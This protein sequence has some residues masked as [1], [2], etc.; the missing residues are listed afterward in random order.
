[1]PAVRRPKRHSDSLAGCA[2]ISQP[3]PG[4][5]ALISA[6]PAVLAIAGVLS[7]LTILWHVA[8][9]FVTHA[10]FDQ[11]LGY[12]LK[13]AAGFRHTHLGPTGKSASSYG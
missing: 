10:A 2:R 8:L 6:L 11:S 5:R 7:G 13:Y 4:S 9:I 3:A 12:G 1:M